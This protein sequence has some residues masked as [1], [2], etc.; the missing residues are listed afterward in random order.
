MHR[1]CGG[2]L[3]SS[4]KGTLV[5]LPLQTSGG[6]W[7]ATGST[8]RPSSA[9]RLYAPF[10]KGSMEGAP[11]AGVGLY[12]LRVPCGKMIIDHPSATHCLHL[13]YLEGQLFALRPRGDCRGAAHNGWPCR[14]QRTHIFLMEVDD[15]RSTGT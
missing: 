7:M 12:R 5:L 10:L 14:Q 15:L 1:E 3:G 6:M 9:A 2:E 13:V 8:G 4:G 11:E